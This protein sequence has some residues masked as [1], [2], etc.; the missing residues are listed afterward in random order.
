[1]GLLLVAGGGGII[2]PSH[3]R[4]RHEFVVLDLSAR[5]G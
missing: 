4:T 5:T 1:M 2:R 3:R